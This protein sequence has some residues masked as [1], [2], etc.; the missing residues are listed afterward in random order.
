M[1]SEW[2][3]KMILWGKKANRDATKQIMLRSVTFGHLCEKL[4]LSEQELERVGVFRAND[5]MR[6]NNEPIGFGGLVHFN[7][8]S[9][10]G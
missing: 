4:G 7:R 2:E 1:A 8:G 3:Q 9:L 6:Q 10:F 5:S